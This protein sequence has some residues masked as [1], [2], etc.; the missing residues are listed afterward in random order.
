M[1]FV[2]LAVGA[3]ML[4]GSAAPPE[5]PSHED[6]ARAFLQAWER[7]RTA[8]YVASGTYQRQTGSNELVSQYVLAQRPPQRTTF[9]FG[10]VTA[11]GDDEG[12][13][14]SIDP[15]GEE[16]CAPGPRR[17]SYKESLNAEITTLLSYFFAADPPLYEVV[18]RGEGCFDLLLRRK[19]PFPAYGYSSLFCFDDATGA[20]IE[21]YQQREGGIDHL[22]VDSIRTEVTDG[23]LAPVLP[24]QPE[25]TPA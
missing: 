7:N 16:V 9:Q 10:N 1:L 13:V 18:D 25:D 6:S 11:V 19:H 5:P 4:A 14:C 8:T 20:L 15:D 22:V 24:E 3:L 2:V 21:L 12:R 23:D 17:D